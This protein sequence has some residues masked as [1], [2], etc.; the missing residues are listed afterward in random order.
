MT[1]G[2][3]VV[4]S[5]MPC[6]E[7]L[8]KGGKSEGFQLWVNLPKKDKMVKPRYQDTP[9]EKIPVVKTPDGKTTVKVIAGESLGTKAIIETRSPIFYL[10]IQ[11]S[12]GASFTQKIPK[13][14]NCFV[15]T[16]RGSG[17]IGDKAVNIGQIAL[18][19]KNGDQITIKGSEKDSI[20]VLLIAGIPINE[21][22]AHRGPFV[23]NTWEEIDQAIRD[24]R[25]GKLGQIDG[26]EERY[27]KTRNAVEQ[28]KSSGTWEKSL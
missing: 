20:H 10:D 26:S 25:N 3:G 2:S 23:M 7:L 6:Q 11:V 9:A 15:Y 24:Y 16:W 28:Q 5:E 21:P 1:A 13:E 12:P 14:Y 4:H 19:S 8:D 22:V 18:L 17:F 27:E